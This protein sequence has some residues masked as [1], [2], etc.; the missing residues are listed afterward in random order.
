M[1]ALLIIGVVVVIISVGL[2]SEQGILRKGAE[3]FLEGTERIDDSG[4]GEYGS[5]KI[6]INPEHEKSITELK[7]LITKLIL[8]N[9]ENCFSKFSGFPNLQEEGTTLKMKY[10]SLTGETDFLV[11][12][13]A[14]GKQVVT[15]MGFTI[16]NM[17]PCVIGGSNQITK[18][19]YDNYLGG[20]SKDPIY[21]PVNEIT[22]TRNDGFWKFEENRINYGNGYIDFEGD[23]WIFMP[24]KGVICFFPTVNDRI[25]FVLGC[26]GSQKEGLD[27]NCFDSS[28]SESIPT[29]VRLGKLDIC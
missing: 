2:F 24:K 20:N 13:G 22:I 23:E 19:F 12:G 25:D 8:G 1:I 11:F 18:G 5:G 15:G 9:K 29:K 28:D 26:G 16:K 7:E 27:N 14:G 17:H 3:S 10:N 4:E 6:E 21:N